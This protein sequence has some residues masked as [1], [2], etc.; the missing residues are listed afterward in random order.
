M[1]LKKKI[2]FLII[3]LTKI[4]LLKK[5]IQSARNNNIK[6]KNRYFNH[7]DKEKLN[8][9]AS[10]NKIIVNENISDNEEYPILNKLENENVNNE[11]NVKEAIPE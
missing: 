1:M 6:K 11:N 5:R 2:N 3:L 9:N 7:F 10:E 4:I 8:K